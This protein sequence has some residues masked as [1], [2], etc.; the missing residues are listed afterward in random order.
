MEILNKPLL[1]LLLL[2]LYGHPREIPFWLILTT[3]YMGPK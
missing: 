1:L 3:I 2:L